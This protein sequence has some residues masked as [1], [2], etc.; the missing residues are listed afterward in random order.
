M[1]PN[2][3]PT[4][5]G[6]R[7]GAW[8]PN[9]CTSCASNTGKAASCILVRASGTRVSSCR[10][11]RSAFTGAPTARPAG[12]TR[13]CLPTS[14]RPAT[15]PAPMPSVSCRA[16]PRSWACLATPC[17][18]ATKT[19]GTTCGVSAACRSTW[20]RLTPGWTT[21][22][23]ASACA[24]SSAKGWTRRWVMSC[25][26]NRLNPWRAPATRPRAPGKPGAGCCVTS[27]CS[28]CPAT[29]PWDGAC[30]WTL[31]PGPP[32]PTGGT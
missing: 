27:A 30:R 25:P 16:S 28:S 2:G 17:C 26:S 18:P 7:S 6:R 21:R 9:W 23:N 1:A 12:K 11:G 31:C 32:P 3:T 4:P 29:R 13:L 14:A 10:A 22:W 20:T 15:T 19:P 5:W 8:P 24:A